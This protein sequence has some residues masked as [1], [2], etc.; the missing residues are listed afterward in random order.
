M[1]KLVAL[2]LVLLLSLSLTACG[3]ADR[4]PAID[5]FNAASAAFDRLT[6]AIN[7]DAEAY[8]DEVHETLTE[9]ADVLQQH[10]A[11]LEGEDDITQELLDEMIVWYGDVEAWVEGAMI[12]LGLG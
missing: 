5:A 9:V 4:Q 12:E 6:A 2:L 10:K 3:G 7:A 11:I 1:K 8:A